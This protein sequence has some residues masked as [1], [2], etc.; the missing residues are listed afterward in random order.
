MA[1][2]VAA[3]IDTGAERRCFHQ[4]VAHSQAQIDSLA[5][6][7]AAEFP[8]LPLESLARYIGDVVE[9]ND[10]IGL[11]SKRSTLPS[12]GRLI[13]HS[14]RLYEFLQEQNVVRGAGGES[15]VDIGSGAGFPG[16]VWKL[17]QPTLAVTL[18][19]RRQKKATFLQR[20]TVVLGLKGVEVVEGDA[21]EVATYERL[22]QH[23]DVATSF[24]VAAPDAIARLVEPFVK[25]GGH[26]C[27]LR[28]REE[29][30]SPE[31]IG[32]TLALVTVSEHG[33]GRFC[34]Y[35]RTEDAAPGSTP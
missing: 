29:M 9:W 22:S 10:R 8:P 17:M 23:F 3:P 19:E 18:V 13:R 33:H 34:V 2:A 25:P 24:A 35:R 26:Y 30:T 6:T 14:A 31:R 7:L 4:M 28:P 1:A 20:T 32:R 5:K 27:T 16:L 11:V 15:V 12:L 21:V